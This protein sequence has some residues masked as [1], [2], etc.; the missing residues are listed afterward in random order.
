MHPVLFQFNTPSIFQGLLPATITIHTYGFLIA[1]GAIVAF[2]Y[3]ARQA[4]RKYSLSYDNAN[5]LFLLLLVASIVGG[6]FFYLFEDTSYYLN[7]PY[8]LISGGGFVFYGSLIFTIPTMYFF[9]RSHKLPWR[10]MLD[11]MAITTCIVHAFGRLGCF[12]AG[13]CHGL[14]YEGIFSVTFTDPN[15]LA[16]PLNTPLHATQL[17]SVFLIVTILIILLRIKKD[18]YLMVNY[19]YPI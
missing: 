3:M 2:I 14:P 17:Y 6:K 4:K 12:G 15:S 10:G 5:M 1:L 13:C 9:F 7:N 16:H 18:K 19:F 8:E 11:I